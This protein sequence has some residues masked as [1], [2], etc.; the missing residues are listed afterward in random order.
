M[1]R[2][3]GDGAWYLRWSFAEKQSEAVAGV[4]SAIVGISLIGYGLIYVLLESD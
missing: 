4:A 2:F 1:H 3:V